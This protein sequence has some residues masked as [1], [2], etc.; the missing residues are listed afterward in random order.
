MSGEAI[1]G[2]IPPLAYLLSSSLFIFGLKRL[3]RVKTARGGNA[4]AAGAMLLA[5]LGTLVELGFVDYRWILGGVVVGG[6]IGA[7]AALRVEMTS[8]PEMVALFNGFGG[9]ASALVSLSVFWHRVV[10]ADASGT[11]AA[12]LG[13]PEA[14][15]SALSILIGALT[16]TGSLVA[17]LKLNGRLAK[18]RPLLMP[19]R[20]ALNLLLVLGALGSGGAFTAAVS[21]VEPLTITVLA[22]TGIAL[23]L[24]ILLVIPIGGADMPVVVSLLNSYSGIAA[25]AA[26]FVIGN[27]ALI[28]AG[29]MVGAAGLILTNLMCKAMNRS[30]VSVL[31]GGFG[32][33]GGA[34]ED[35]EYENVKSAGPEEAAML[36]ENAESVIVVPG[37]GLAV[38]QAQHA[39]KELAGALEERGAKVRYCIHPVAGRMPGHMNVLLAEADV[40]YEQLVELDK[41]NAD[42]KTTDV[43]IVLGANDVA[44]P[45][46]IEDPKS[47]IAGMPIANV[48]EARTVFVIKR[49]LSPGYAGI[50]NPLFERDN[51]M[52]L[53]GDAKDMVQS[54]LE[55]LK[56]L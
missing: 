52:M 11:G 1:R 37:Y 41:I 24:G 33:E 32:Q 47:P 10:E 15:T 30:L 9:A 39:V 55:E 3:S 18:G 35:S 51:T 42:F 29:A 54:I 8:M 40:P 49:S 26:G 36:L 22:L 31:L 46:A 34:Q 44:N 56:E 6:L 21:G 48:H 16:F 38:A 20:H 25:S 5:V 2:A 45:S 17:F 53:F 23:L 7:V 43:A 4:L 19:G 50:K 28:I 12:S 13:A 27:P 14:V